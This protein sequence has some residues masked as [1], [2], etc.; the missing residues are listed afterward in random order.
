MT[1]IRNLF[2]PQRGLQRSIEKVI[3]YQASQE[4]RLKA[5]ISEYIVT[6]SID[7]Q[8]EVLLEKI[9][10][11]LDSGGGHEIGVWVSGFYGSG[12]SSFTKYLGLA[13]DDSIQVDGQP[14][15]RHLN[16]RLTRP[17]TKALLDAVNKRLS[18]AVIML[19]LAS[20]QIAGATLAEVSTVLFYKVLQELGYSR[21]MKVAALDVNSK[22]ISAMKN[23]ERYSKKL[24]RI[25]KISRTTIWWLIVC[26]QTLRTGCILLF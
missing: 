13:L 12:K 5:E 19:D 9:Q 1:Q 26:F 17:Q 2:D 7:Q 3:S 6:D 14:F 21:N 20:Q 10:T 24:E 23:S 11:A 8:L 16:D 15:S 25:G 18:A 22:R 4:D